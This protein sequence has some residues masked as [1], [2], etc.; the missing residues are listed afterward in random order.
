M[1][2]KENLCAL[3]V[4]T[5][6]GMATVENSVEVPKK[7]KNRTTMQFSNSTTGCLQF[8]KIT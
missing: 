6:T 3:L 7:T 5:Q 8:I 1:W 2:R 4:G